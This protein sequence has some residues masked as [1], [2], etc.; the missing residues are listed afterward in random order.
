[1]VITSYGCYAVGITHGYN[2]NPGEL[3]GAAIYCHDY[4]C[5]VHDRPTIQVDR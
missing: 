2:P 3:G 4:T 1:M 5:I